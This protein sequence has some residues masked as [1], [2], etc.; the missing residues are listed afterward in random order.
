MYARH[1]SNDGYSRP[2]P[3]TSPM[4]YWTL[5]GLIDTSEGGSFVLHERMHMRTRMK[6]PK[7]KEKKKE[8]KEITIIVY[9]EFRY[10]RYGF[11]FSFCSPTR[12]HKYTLH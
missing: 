6:L 10:Y 8:G 11:L 5:I 4:T 9:H 3:M 2:G 7:H 1:V 12:I